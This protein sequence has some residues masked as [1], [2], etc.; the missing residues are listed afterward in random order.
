MATPS[1]SVKIST[2]HA[3]RATPTATPDVSLPPRPS[4]V[5]SSVGRA[6]AC[7]PVMTGTVPAASRAWSRVVSI[8]STS[9][10]TWVPSE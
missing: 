9:A 2:R 1:T 4:V 7:P 8:C 6:T 3:P 10:S 5:K